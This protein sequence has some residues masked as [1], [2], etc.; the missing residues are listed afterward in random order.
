MFFYIPFWYSLHTRLMT[1]F[2]RFAWVFTYLIPVLIV[3]YF[4]EVPLLLL[5]LVVLSVYTVY[6]IGY[7]FNDCELIKNEV[8]PTI[9]VTDEE[10]CFYEIHKYYILF[11]RFL[12]ILVLLLVVDF[13]YS[14][15]LYSYIA[16]V[17]SILIFYI[18]YNSNRSLINL[19]LYSFLVFLRYFGFFM[20]LYND[21]VLFLMF[22]LLYPLC[23][24]IE[25]S[26][27]KRFVTS[28]FVVIKSFDYFRCV[29]YFVLVVFSGLIYFFDI[30]YS[31]I[32]LFIAIY[33]FVYRLFSYFF[34]V[35]KF[36]G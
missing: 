4:F 32:F 15:F 27:K 35:N 29:Y 13:F 18:L 6:E 16:T 23:V 1:K 26:S 36:R 28:S 10:I 17:F 5:L 34:L 7:I 9:R 3:G 8:N 22:F 11:F 14:S 19:P 24:T 2:S 12:I 25:F 20:F 31:N 21:I 33:F 30:K